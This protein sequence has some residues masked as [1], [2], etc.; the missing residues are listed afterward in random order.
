MAFVVHALR[1]EDLFVDVGANIGSYTVLASRVRGAST[2][3]VEPLPGTFSRLVAN[4]RVNGIEDRVRALNLGL[5]RKPGSL[6]FTRSLDCMNHVATSGEPDSTEV[7]VTTLD[8]IVDERAPLVMKIDVEGFETEV[9]AGG[10]A[11]L[12]RPDLRALIIELN[13]SGARY[14]HDDAKLRREIERMGFH[15]QLYDPFTRLL[16]P[17]TSIASGN[18]LYVRDPTFFERRLSTAPPVRVLGTKL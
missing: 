9:L 1:A 5:A 10:A 3:A 2:I 13:G 4:I 8:A 18:A 17:P 14:G 7:P 11:T 12:A 6:R 16:R 15:E